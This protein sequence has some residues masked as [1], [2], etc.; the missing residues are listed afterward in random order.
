MFLTDI[1]S[2]SFDSTKSDR[3]GILFIDFSISNPIQKMT[4]DKILFL[5]VCPLI[6]PKNVFRKKC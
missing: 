5:G 2:S 6:G 4:N 1:Y 3:L